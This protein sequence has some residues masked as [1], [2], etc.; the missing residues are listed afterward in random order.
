MHT[1]AGAVSLLFMINGKG[2]KKQKWRNSN[3]VKMTACRP[4]LVPR[5]A[6]RSSGWIT[7]SGDVESIRW[8]VY[9][10]PEQHMLLPA[11]IQ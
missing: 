2:C 9:S 4:S 10:R 3:A 1:S 8:R 5:P 11:V 7:R 6:I